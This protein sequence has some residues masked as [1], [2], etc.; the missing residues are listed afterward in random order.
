MTDQEVNKIIAEYMCWTRNE[1]DTGW[2]QDGEDFI[3][4]WFT[5]SLDALVPVWEKLRGFDRI[6]I[7]I[8]NYNN[9]FWFDKCYERSIVTEVFESS[10]KTLQQAAAHAT[11][12]AILELGNK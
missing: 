8:W 4:P 7:D 11:A 2:Y 5:K 6:G 10:H 12:K 9:S 1:Y 3:A